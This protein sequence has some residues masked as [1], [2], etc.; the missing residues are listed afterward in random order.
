[1]NKFNFGTFDS[2]VNDGPFMD[3][4]Y[5]EP[6]SEQMTRKELSYPLHELKTWINNMVTATSNDPN[7]I[8]KFRITSDGALEYSTDGE[9]WYGPANA[10]H[11]IYDE[12]NNI[13]AQKS[14]LKFKYSTVYNEGDATIVEG[15]PGERGP[16]GA[17]GKK[18]EKGDKGDSGNSFVILGLYATLSALEEDHPIGNVGDAWAVGD[19]D[20]NTIYLWD[21]ITSA[22]TDVGGI[23]GPAGE[24]GVGIV[25]ISKTGSAGLVDT[26]TVTY[27][28]GDTDTFTVTNGQ[29]GTNGTNGV[30][31]PAGGYVGEIIAKSSDETDYATYWK[32][33]KT[34]NNNSLL[35]STAADIAVQ[36]TLVSGTNIKTIDNTSLLGSGNISTS[37]SYSNITVSGTPTSNGG[38]NSWDTQEQYGYKL[39]ITVAGVTANSLILN[40]VMDDT[41]LEAIAPVIT[42]GT[43]KLTVYTKDN[44]ALSGTIQVL[45]TREV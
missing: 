39:D 2:S 44:T 3:G 11:V 12:N 40:I 32:Y 19:E 9:S 23:Q 16:E 37:A 15:I 17:P 28:D 20:S 26:Y 38:Y 13:L 10:G 7:V 1:M 21:T 25:S 35:S 27:S 43:N 42:T 8:V 6:T 34:I 30:G 36:E 41:L 24:E 18:G 33:L 4:S 29:N 31:V 22:W 5:T 45:V 14:R